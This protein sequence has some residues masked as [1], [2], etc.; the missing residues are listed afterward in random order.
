LPK[1]RLVEET[2]AV[3]GTAAVPAKVTVCGLLPAL[4]A[5]VSV[6]VTVAGDEEVNVTLMAQLAPTPIPLPQVLVWA[7][8]LAG[9]T[10]ILEKVRDALPELVTVTLCAGLVTP[11]TVERARLAEERETMGA[12][13]VPVPLKA[14]VC[15]LPA[16][17]PRLSVMV[18]VPERVPSAEGVKVT[19][20]VQ[21][22]EGARLFPQLLDWEKSLEP[23]LTAIR[24]IERA[25]VPELLSVTAKGALERSIG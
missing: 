5:M 13:P 9:A 2:V 6:P 3:A 16:T 23:A 10:V 21:I 20:I 7:K 12:G 25:S 14:T 4:S 18:K 22:E 17:P 11:A 19:L 1:V 24:A 8:L 15:M